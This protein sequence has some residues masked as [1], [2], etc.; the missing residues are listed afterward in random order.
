MKVAASSVL[1][2]AP[3]ANDSAVAGAR[4][5][6]TPMISVRS[7]SRSRIV[8]KP[9]IPE[10]E[11]DRH[12]HGVELTG[13][14]E[15]FVRV[16][17][18]AEAQIDGG[19]TARPRGRAARRAPPNAPAPLGSRCRARSVRHRSRASPR[20]CRGCC[21]AAATIVTATPAARPA[22]AMLWP[23]LPRVA[24]TTPVTVGRSRT[25]RS[26]YTSPP[27]TLNAPVGV[28]SSCLTHTSAPS[29]FAEQRPGELRRRRHV[30]ADHGRGLG[31]LVER[32]ERRRLSHA[33]TTAPTRTSCAANGISSTS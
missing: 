8:I 12:V 1:T 10:P 30:P 33:D 28:Q 3:A 22:N 31:E 11:P 23:W 21:R 26:M 13:G 9:Q 14:R 25:K 19:T 32:E 6:T 5:A 20:S 27:R 17:R 2:A 29:R 7:P 15:Q 4:S 24:Q 16:G 18:Y